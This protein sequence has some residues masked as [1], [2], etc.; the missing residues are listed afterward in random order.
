M[1]RRV[2]VETFMRRPGLLAL[3]LLLPGCSG[4][5]FWQYQR[6]SFTL[7]GW[8]PNKPVGTSENYVRSLQG[9]THWQ[10]GEHSVLLT[11]GGDIW[12]GPPRPVPTLKDL[13]KAQTAEINGQANALAPLPALPSL[14]GY[15]ITPP[16]PGSPPP[17]TTFPGALVRV[18]GGRAPQAI[19][20]TAGTQPISGPNGTI[21]VP[22]GN[23]TSTV[24][25]PN[26]SVSTIPSAPSSVQR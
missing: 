5:G 17:P 24:I 23:G 18:P 9:Q 7:P 13:Q 4:S 22:N 10:V 26:G 20:G 15:E 25:G 2:F 19:M 21:I 6:D 3:A 14:P 16:P 1:V 8:N 12:P 11:E